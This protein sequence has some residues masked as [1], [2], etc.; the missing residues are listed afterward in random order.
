MYTALEMARNAWI[1]VKYLGDETVEAV[2]LNWVEG[3]S[4]YWPGYD[5]NRIT[6]GNKEV[7]GGR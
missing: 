5:A 7:R 6:S 4:C 3:N 1:I 2:P